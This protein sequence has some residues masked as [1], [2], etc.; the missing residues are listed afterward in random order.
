MPL[1]ESSNCGF[2]EQWHD[3]WIVGGRGT[4]MKEK[5]PRKGR[6]QFQGVM[7]GCKTG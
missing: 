1:V 7:E 2:R 6:K 3:N 4:R 5:G